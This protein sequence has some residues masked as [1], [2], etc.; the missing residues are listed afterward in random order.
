MQA[1]SGH[2]F[3]MRIGSLDGAQHGHRRGL[4][5]TLD[6]P[7]SELPQ[8]AW[9]AAPRRKLSLK[10]GERRDGTAAEVLDQVDN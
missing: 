2:E 3:V 7:R 8:F 4:L 6:C 9:M 5:H 1:Q 10:A